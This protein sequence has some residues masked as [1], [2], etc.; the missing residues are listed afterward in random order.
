MKHTYMTFCVYIAHSDCIYRIYAS[1]NLI[2]TLLHF[3]FTFFS[4][5]LFLLDFYA[6][7]FSV[8][9]L[10]LQASKNECFDENYLV[11]SFL[12][13]CLHLFLMSKL[14]DKNATLMVDYAN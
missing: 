1:Y 10:Y 8:A 5:L 3:N 12:C 14:I 11:E 9:F 6:C 2:Y 7:V 4:T 13:T